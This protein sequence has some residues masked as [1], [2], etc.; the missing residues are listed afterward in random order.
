MARRTPLRYDHRGNASALASG[1]PGV[2]E[3]HP[4]HGHD[5][6]NPA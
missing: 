3:G 6:L 5:D 1:A 2:P 4:A